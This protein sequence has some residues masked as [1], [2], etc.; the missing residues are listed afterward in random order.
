MIRGH[1]GGRGEEGEGGELS[2]APSDTF[3]DLTIL[4]RSAIIS[5]EPI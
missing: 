1:A 5:R 4:S 3:D 2:G